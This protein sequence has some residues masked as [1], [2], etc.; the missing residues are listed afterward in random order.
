MG[1]GWAFSSLATDLVAGLA[2]T[3]AATDV[4]VADGPTGAVSVQR[5]HGGAAATASWA[6]GRPSFRPTARRSS[7]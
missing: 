3:N 6:I 4:F 5:R 1:R 2:D 7:S